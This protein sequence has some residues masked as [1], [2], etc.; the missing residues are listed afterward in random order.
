M[1]IVLIKMQ[2][3]IKGRVT[4]IIS[5]LLGHTLQNVWAQIRTIMAMDTSMASGAALLNV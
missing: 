5:V 3:D 2:T 1:N 4:P